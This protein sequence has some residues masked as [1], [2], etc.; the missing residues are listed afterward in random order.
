MKPI[1]L[2]GVALLPFAACKKNQLNG[3]SL[4]TGT[5]AHHSKPIPN[6]TVYVKFGAKEFPGRD[7]SVYDAHVKAD[8][9]GVYSVTCYRGNYYLFATGVDMQAQPLYVNGGVPVRVRSNEDVKAE[10]A[11]TEVN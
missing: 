8:A 3:D 11:V 4:I 1:L 9:M 10:V 2:A 6:A 5:V 7:S